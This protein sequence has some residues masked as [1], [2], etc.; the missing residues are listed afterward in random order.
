M[1]PFNTIT[2]VKDKKGIRTVSWVGK[3]AML[4]SLLDCNQ[5]IEE[6][7]KVESGVRAFLNRSSWLGF[8]A[9][10]HDTMAKAL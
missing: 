9:D 3:S 1:T 7:C 10:A 8:K 5:T 4:Q 6:E 2:A